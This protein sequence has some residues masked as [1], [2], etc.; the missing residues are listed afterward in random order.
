MTQLLLDTRGRAVPEPAQSILTSP[1]AL[2]AR[3]QVRVWI[4]AQDLERGDQEAYDRNTAEAGRL[5]SEAAE[6]ESF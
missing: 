4:A 1:E 6:R 2:R 3:A 5:L